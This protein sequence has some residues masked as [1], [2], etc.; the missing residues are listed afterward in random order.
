MDGE[1]GEFFAGFGVELLFD[2]F[3]V[4]GDGFHAE[5]EAR[6]DL[7][8][9]ETVADRLEY[10]PFAVAQLPDERGDLA[11]KR[12]TSPI[13]SGSQ[14]SRGRLQ[15]AARPVSDRARSRASS[16]RPITCSAARVDGTTF[17]TVPRCWT[18][19]LLSGSW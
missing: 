4:G 3:A 11:F 10:L 15:A 5:V 14:G 16:A 12:D 1:A 18:K 8:G 6:S 19:S 17:Q 7:V 9:G 2:V 13:D